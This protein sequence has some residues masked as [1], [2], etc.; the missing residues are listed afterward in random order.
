VIKWEFYNKN[1]GDLIPIRA[2]YESLFPP[3]IIEHFDYRFI[4]IPISILV[5]GLIFIYRKLP[6]KTELVLSVLNEGERMIIDVI[7]KEG[8]EKVDQ[9]KIVSLSGF[10]KAKVSRILKSLQ[11]RG[12]V[13]LERVGRK[14]RVSLRK[15]IFKQ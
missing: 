15:V 6:K 3:S 11:E 9:R 14:N 1:P 10:S 7:R 8:K 5:V 2:Y 12:V 4:L 13:D